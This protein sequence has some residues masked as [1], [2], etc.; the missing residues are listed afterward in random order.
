MCQPMASVL[1]DWPVLTL[2]DGQLQALLA[3]RLID[4]EARQIDAL[5]ESPA[6]RVRLIDAAGALVGL[7][8]PSAIGS[9]HADIVLR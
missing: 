6:E 8:R 3:G 4:L 7:A 1:Q 2:D 5:G 9:L